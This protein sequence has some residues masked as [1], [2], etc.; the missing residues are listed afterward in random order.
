MPK[1]LEAMQAASELASVMEDTGDTCKC[2]KCGHVG[3]KEDFMSDDMS[4]EGE[5]EEE[6]TEEV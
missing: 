6:D 5:Y 1:D 2:P 3:A 4:S